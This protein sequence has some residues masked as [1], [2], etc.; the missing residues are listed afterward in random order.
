M[1]GQLCTRAKYK[2]KTK[3][4][5]GKYDQ[6]TTKY[7]GTVTKKELAIHYSYYDLVRRM[8]LKSEVERQSYYNNGRKDD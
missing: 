4:Q 2:S 8:E 3:D 5:S 1:D 6:I 7:L